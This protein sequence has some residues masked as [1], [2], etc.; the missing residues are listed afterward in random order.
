[1]ETIS[2]GAAA[3]TFAD[4]CPGTDELLCLAP[5]VPMGCRLVALSPPSVPPVFM[6]LEVS[7]CAFLKTSALW[8][9][10]SLNL[11]ASLQ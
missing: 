5:S 11:A 3:V 10:S 6:L 8:D 9:P 2:D 4:I 7:P 1:M